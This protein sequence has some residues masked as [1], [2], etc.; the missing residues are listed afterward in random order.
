VGIVLERGACGR[1]L[2]EVGARLLFV[3]YDRSHGNSRP[4]Q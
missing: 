1:E 3:S 2:E 4:G